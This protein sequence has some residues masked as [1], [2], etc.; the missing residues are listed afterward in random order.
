M[1][2]RKFS[3]TLARTILQTTVVEVTASSKQ[4]AAF[5]AGVNLQPDAV[6]TPDPR[7]SLPRVEDVREV[8]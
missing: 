4:G 5:L 1:A 6:W 3:V 8:E 7:E 2:L